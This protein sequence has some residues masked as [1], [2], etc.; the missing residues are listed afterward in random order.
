MFRPSRVAIAAL[1]LMATACSDSDNDVVHTLDAVTVRFVNDTDTPLA[2]FTGN[3]TGPANATLAFGDATGCMLIDLSNVPAL[4]VTNAT[5]G[6]TILFTPVLLAGTNVTVV[7]FA[8]AA[9]T[10]QFAQLPNR[11]VPIANTAGLRF[12][13]GAATTAPLDMARNGAALTPFTPFGAASG[14]VSVPTDSGRITFSNQSSVVLDLGEQ[15]FPQGENSMV[16][17][18]RPAPNTV[19]LRFFT[20]RG[21]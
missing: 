10:V 20:V 5:T 13:H 6:A 17:L 19:P 16:V 21:C 11:F 15:A 2:I 18:G 12:F 3:I 9:G 4:A 8:D 7:A 14:F 1:A